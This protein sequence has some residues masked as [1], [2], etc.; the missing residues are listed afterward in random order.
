MARVGD[1]KSV[2]SSPADHAGTAGVVR[3][4]VEVWRGPP[5]GNASNRVVDCVDRETA[6]ALV[7]NGVSHVVMMA[8]PL[9]LEA[10]ALGFSLSEG[11]VDSA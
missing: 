5:A 7:Y 3:R 11:I 9:D 6:V 1:K 10:F 8:T 4:T 2:Q